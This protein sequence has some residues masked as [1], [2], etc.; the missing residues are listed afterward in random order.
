LQGSFG[1]C[2]PKTGGPDPNCVNV[3]GNPMTYA[4]SVTFNFSA[5]YRFAL[6]NGDTLTPRINFAHISGQWASLFD[7]AALG[8]RLG[9][10]DLLGAQLGWTTCDN[11]VWT[12]YA[13][14]LLDKQYVTAV[15]SGGLYAGPPRQFGIRLSKF[16]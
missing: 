16:F 3:K 1:T 8:D 2:D 6:G 15:D 13:T 11:M 5:E 7:N 12:L 4:P 10:R 14:N 9:V